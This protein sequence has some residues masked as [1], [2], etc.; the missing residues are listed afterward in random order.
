MSRYEKKAFDYLE[1]ALQISR[2][3][4]NRGAEAFAL[5]SHGMAYRLVNRYETATELYPTG[6][7]DLPRDQEPCG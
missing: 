2:E 3:V 7:G 5:S 4:K 1:Q 6:A